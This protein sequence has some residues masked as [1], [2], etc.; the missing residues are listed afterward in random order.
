MTTATQSTPI[1]WRTLAVGGC[2]GY[3]LALLVTL[4]SLPSNV[5][6]SSTTRQLDEAVMV[7]EE[8]EELDVVSQRQ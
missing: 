2:L 6:K 7:E 4:C 1:S 5:D 3:L 8:E